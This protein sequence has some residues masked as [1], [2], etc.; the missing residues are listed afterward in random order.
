MLRS[1]DHA[2]RLASTT[3]LAPRLVTLALATIVAGCA[4]PQRPG[5]ADVADSVEAVRVAADGAEAAIAPDVR[6]AGMPP[7]VPPG[8]AMPEGSLQ[9]VAVDPP[10]G[11][12]LT[13]HALFRFAFDRPVDPRSIASGAVTMEYVDPGVVLLV[14]PFDFIRVALAD[15]GRTMLV[16]PP[17]LLAGKTIRVNLT[18]ALR[19]RDESSLAGGDAEAPPPGV[20]RTFTYRVLELPP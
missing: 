17:E 4:A 16:E 14:D 8:V 2:A 10:E 15:E 7:A 12:S 19:G 13:T 3:P 5:E 9:L 6:A 20:R 18:D 11:A 1:I